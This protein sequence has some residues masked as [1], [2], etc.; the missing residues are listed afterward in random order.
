[1]KIQ[2][3]CYTRGK[4]LDYNVFCE[5]DNIV[6]TELSKVLA[7]VM[8][9]LGDNVLDEKK[10][11]QKPKWL[12][13]KERDYIIWG[14]CCM[15]EELCSNSH[16]TCDNFGRQI[17]GFFAVVISDYTSSDVRL[18]Y[19]KEY[20]RDLYNKEIAQHYEDY[21]SHHSSTEN[22]LD[23]NYSYIKTSEQDLYQLNTNKSKCKALN[24]AN[25]KSVLE[26]ALSKDV[27]SLI[28]DNDN[29]EQATNKDGA[30]MNCLSDDIPCGNYD[31]EQSTIE[32][33][34][35]KRDSKQREIKELKEELQKN[36]Q[37]IKKLQHKIRYMERIIFFIVLLSIISFYYLVKLRMK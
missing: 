15:N 3:Y 31:I 26:A 2:H 12:L 19:G 36:E 10:L 33:V 6:D 5:P 8:S 34:V 16:V 30:F 4:N 35:P 1:M 23:N 17:R 21:L 20:F 9:I 24:E 11:K 37:L 32:P 25:K 29:I 22:Y 7:K 13:I 27:I 28:I 18:P 14:I